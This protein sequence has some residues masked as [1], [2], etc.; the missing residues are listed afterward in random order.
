MVKAT[1]LL[2]DAMLFLPHVETVELVRVIAHEGS[3]LL[4]NSSELLFSQMC[5]MNLTELSFS[6]LRNIHFIDS[7][8][9]RGPN[10]A[11]ILHLDRLVLA[12][13]L[14]PVS[15]GDAEGHDRGGGHAG[16]LY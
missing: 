15:K 3:W 5:L 1:R 9:T 11:E 7:S 6:D 16:R 2:Y 14:V 12:S 10:A 8:I 4:S 13:L